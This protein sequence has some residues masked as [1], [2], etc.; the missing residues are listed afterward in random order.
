MF[1][2]EQS[3]KDLTLIYN[4]TM[5]IEQECKEAYERGR[6]D[7][8]VKNIGAKEA[9]EEIIRVQERERVIQEIEDMEIQVFN[10]HTEFSRGYAFAASKIR[11]NIIKQIKL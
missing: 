2:K 10:D 1:Q 11:T 5:D 9:V 4:K 6:L 3:K 8:F 7:E